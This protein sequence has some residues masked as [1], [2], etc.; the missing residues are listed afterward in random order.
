MKMISTT[1]IT[2][3]RG[4][5]LIPVI[6]PSPSSED[7]TGL[8]LALDLGA[9]GR[10]QA[11]AQGLGLADQIAHALLS[12]LKANTHGSATSRPTA[13]ATSASDKPDITTSGPAPL[14]ARSWNA[15]MT[16]STVPKQAE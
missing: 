6:A 14:V 16:P 12:E 2:S 8:S 11:A 15:L 9:S 13:V 1:R 3:T 7:C 10:P 5:T 4:V